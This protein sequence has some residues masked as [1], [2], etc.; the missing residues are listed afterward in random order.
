M[1]LEAARHAHSQNSFV[2]KQVE[3]QHAATVRVLRGELLAAEARIKQAEAAAAAAIGTAKMH[4][5][6]REGSAEGGGASSALLREER[7]ICACLLREVQAADSHEARRLAVDSARARTAGGGS[8]AESEERAATAWQQQA[9]LRALRATE[10]QLRADLEVKSR[11][12]ESVT[13]QLQGLILQQLQA[14]Q[15]PTPSSK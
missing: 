6:A 14:A 15:K 13:E 10:A 7:V 4:A 9:E 11:E 8:S 5:E 12:V 2:L 3:S 1:E